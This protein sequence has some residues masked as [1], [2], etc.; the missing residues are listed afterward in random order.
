M[1]QGESVQTASDEKEERKRKHQQ[2][3]EEAE[4]EQVPCASLLSLKSSMQRW[5][6]GDGR[7]GAEAYQGSQEGPPAMFGPVEISQR[8]SAA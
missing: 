3:E 5:L 2:V 4:A 7:R 6:P 1:A 8:D